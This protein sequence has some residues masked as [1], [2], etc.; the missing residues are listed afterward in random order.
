MRGLQ[1]R[2]ACGHGLAGAAVGVVYD[3]RGLITKVR[4]C[5]SHAISSTQH[6]VGGQS[7]LRLYTGKHVG[8]ATISEQR[9]DCGWTRTVGGWT[10][11]VPVQ[12]I[13]S[14]FDSHSGLQPQLAE[15]DCVHRIACPDSFADI[16]VVGERAIRFEA[17]AER[18]RIV[19]E[20]RKYLVVIRR[21][22]R[23]VTSEVV[24]VV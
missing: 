2:I 22:P 16:E 17:S 8:V 9:R 19:V 1:V 12:V 7:V 13:P 23:G 6:G 18:S 21:G 4:P 11:H 24:I 20:E 10:E 15:A 14:C 5:D 3:E